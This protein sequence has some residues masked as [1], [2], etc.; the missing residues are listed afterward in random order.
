M[1]FLFALFRGESLK[2]FR[3]RIAG[4][5]A[6]FKNSARDCGMHKLINNTKLRE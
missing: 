1:N 5:T 3:D 6:I 2:H 4:E